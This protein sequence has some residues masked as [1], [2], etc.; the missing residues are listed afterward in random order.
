[1]NNRSSSTSSF[2]RDQLAVN[3]Q[4]CA[5]LV[6]K[7]DKKDPLIR[8]TIHDLTYYLTGK[9]VRHVVNV[10]KTVTHVPPPASPRTSTTTTT[11]AAAA[12]A[13]T[14]PP[15]APAAASP[16]I[17][18]TVSK[19]HHK[20]LGDVIGKLLAI[21]DESTAVKSDSAKAATSAK[22]AAR[23]KADVEKSA[24]ATTSAASSSATTKHVSTDWCDVHFTRGCGCQSQ[25]QRVSQKPAFQRPSNPQSTLVANGWIE[26]LRRSKMRPVWKDVLA[27][28]VEGRR[29]GEVT[30]L[31]IQRE[32][33]NEHTGKMEL[34]ALNQIPVKWIQEIGYSSYSTENRFTVKVF[35]LQEEFVF[36]CANEEA[37]QN[38]VL[39]LRSMQETAQKAA[40]KKPAEEALPEWDEI[41]KTHRHSSSF[42]EEKKAPEHPPAPIPG[43]PRH[44]TAPTPPQPT[45]SNGMPQPSPPAAAAD[46]KPV[47]AAAQR[48]SVKELRA[49]AH[50]AGITTHGME[51]GELE[52]LVQ[53]LFANV[54]V[55][56][57]AAPTNSHHES[58]KESQ[59]PDRI[60]AEDVGKRQ[61]EAEETRNRAA[62]EAAAKQRQEAEAAARQRQQQQ[63]AEAAARQ[64]QQQE[65]E[66]AARQ[67]QQE[68]AEAAARIRAAAEAAM[69]RQRQQLDEA[70][71]QEM[72][73]RQREEAERQRLAA[74]RQRR[75]E[76]EHRRRL[77]EMQAAEERRRK[78]EQQRQ[79]QQQWQE[80]QRRWQEQQAADEQRRQ[81]EAQRAAEDRRRQEETFRMHQQWQQRANAPPPPQQWQH[82][83][84]QYP[85][86]GQV[87]PHPAPPNFPHGPPP[88]VGQPPP[89]HPSAANHNMKYAKMAG[90]S[91]DGMQMTIQRIRHG[92]L[93]EWA[94]QPPAMQSL[95]P[96]H[97][98]ISS[99]HTVF[100]PKFGVPLHEHFQK[101]TIVTLPELMSGAQPDD[102]KL[103]KVVRKLRLWL[104]PDK[105]PR[106]F[107]EEHQ[108]MC[109]MLWDITSDAFEDHKKREEE[110]GWM[111]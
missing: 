88:G 68:E 27:S 59:L 107:S 49:I 26:Q 108:F 97:H 23:F 79:Q 109:K 101:W 104:H 37:A 61:R 12:I 65:A 54:T 84:P 7:G 66:A 24:A 55:S 103:K 60:D 4:K 34:E 5:N 80:Q 91:G 75:E 87:P 93:V 51:R 20:G 82:P 8:Q 72:E 94:L 33:Q 28:I 62:A 100:P 98:L 47:A 6:K 50:G 21:H 95:R 78:E 15:A 57:A 63:E 90:E 46:A 111:R 18:T 3:L 40:R 2:S 9:R 22:N 74:E 110:L 73:K 32:K 30:T 85:P 17:T 41:P 1:V 92:I 25:Q 31:W 96:I 10:Q 69:A 52:R 102:E 53:Q 14:N 13:S 58:N 70:K 76:E 35:N 89:Q 29:P 16:V 39:T 42:E 64:R 86:H 19:H 43:G 99:I 105:L 48:M 83:P 81:A 44:P 71:R 11:A 45:S 38:W 77:A 106:E 36:R 56:S 67:R